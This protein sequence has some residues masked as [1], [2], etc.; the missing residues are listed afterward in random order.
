MGLYPPNVE[1]YRGRLYFGLGSIRGWSNS[2]GTVVSSAAYDAFGSVASATGSPGQFRFTG[3]QWDAGTGLEYLRARQY[4]PTVG[5][6]VSADSVQPNAPGT[7]GWN[8]YAY[9]ANNPTTWVDPTGH[10][11]WPPLRPVTPETLAPLVISVA[12]T[13]ALTGLGFALRDNLVFL[14]LVFS[15]AWVLADL[16]TAVA[17]ED[18]Y[19][20][21]GHPRHEYC[22]NIIREGFDRCARIHSTSGNPTH[23][24]S[25]WLRQC[26]KAILEE[27]QTCL[28]G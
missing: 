10:A 2:S 4:D 14:A 5:R 20:D 16:W 18:E 23:R 6:F 9:V 24:T 11:T 13:A 3:E 25:E 8:L 17:V 26:R 21:M 1:R 12:A 7:Q 27:Y 28:N 22:K 19:G 15:G